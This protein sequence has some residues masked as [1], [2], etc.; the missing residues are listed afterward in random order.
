M[1]EVFGLFTLADGTPCTGVVS[2][3]PTERLTDLPGDTPI[4]PGESWR[5][6][7]SAFVMPHAVVVPLVAGVVS[8]TLATT[9]D[10]DLLEPGWRYRV[11]EAVG[12]GAATYMIEL[13]SGDY[14]YDLA[15]EVR[16]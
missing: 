8:V 4:P 3:T 2:F 10:E 12:E 14:P 16:P 15:Q 13:P 6:R 1:R 11:V 7:D 9:D 5:P